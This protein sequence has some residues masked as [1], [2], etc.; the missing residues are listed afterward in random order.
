MFL[1]Y[2]LEV[3]SLLIFCLLNCSSTYRDQ[4]YREQTMA[5]L[6]NHASQAQ[7]K[8]ISYRYANLLAASVPFENPT[9]VTEQSLQAF[10]TARCTRASPGQLHCCSKQ[11]CKEKLKGRFAACNHLPNIWKN[12][13]LRRLEEGELRLWKVSATHYSCVCGL[14]VF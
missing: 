4:D 10:F 12:M 8:W 1:A 3:G 13:V 7:C 2:G 6:A 5:E 11:V 14:F 9:Y